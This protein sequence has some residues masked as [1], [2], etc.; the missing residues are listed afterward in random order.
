MRTRTYQLSCLARLLDVPAAELGDPTY[1]G[2]AA[3]LAKLER[4][5]RAE[6]ARGL[7]HHWTYEVGRH[8]AIYFAYGAEREAFLRD[9]GVEPPPASE[10]ALPRKPCGPIASG[11]SAYSS[12]VSPSINDTPGHRSRG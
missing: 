9:F 3:L 2:R 4:L 7:A 11:R 12:L 1:Y 6:R 10:S 8:R 5:L